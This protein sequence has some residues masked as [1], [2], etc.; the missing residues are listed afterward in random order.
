MLKAELFDELN[1]EFTVLS[2]YIA[3][4]D[5]PVIGVAHYHYITNNVM[6][7]TFHG[8]ECNVNRITLLVSRLL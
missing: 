5:I 2:S 4:L 6:W 7:M 8:K 1:Y 3:F